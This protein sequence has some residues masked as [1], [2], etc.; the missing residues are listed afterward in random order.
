[1]VGV[2]ADGSGL[3]TID[4]GSSQ[5]NAPVGWLPDN[6]TIIYSAM[7]G[8]GFTFRR[9]HLQSG[10]SQDLFTVQSKAGFGSLSPDG[11]WLLFT[12]RP[13]GA[14]MP[15]TYITRLD[16][17]E[18]RQVA[19]PQIPA[20]FISVWGP[21]GQWLVLN[22]VNTENPDGNEIPVLVNPFTCQVLHVNTISGS[23]E[24]WSP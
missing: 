13:F 16:G 4:T 18:R 21:D 2:N 6:Q 9:Y 1:V 19:D 7:G 15:G 3:Q 10:E 23:V 17:S 14:I 24:G 20:S 22:T 12:D 5:V 8:G 11:Q